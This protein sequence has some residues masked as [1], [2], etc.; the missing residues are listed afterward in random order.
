MSLSVGDIE[1]VFRL[2]D[3]FTPALTFIQERVEVFEH[4]VE[5]TA[6]RA[7]VAFD[8]MVRS[9]NGEHIAM[10]AA[11]IVQALDKIGGKAILTEAE[12]AR[13]NRTLDAA[14]LK[15][16]AMGIAIPAGL[17]PH[18]AAMDLAAQEAAE[19][20]T[21]QAEM[22]VWRRVAADKIALE[23]EVNRA[24][25]A[26]LKMREAETI[27]AA[28]AESRA[29]K[30]V[31]AEQIATQQAHIARLTQMGNAWRTV[32]R[33][34]VQVG[35]ALSMYVTL[36]LVAAGVAAVYFAAGF[37]QNMVKLVT[38]SAVT[39]ENML[40]MRSAVLALSPAVAVGPRELSEA[41]LQ[42]T[43]TGIR[44]MEAMQIL[45]V[46][47]KGAA[48]GM[49]STETVA[50][51]LTSVMVAY[52]GSGLTA[53]R[54][55]DILYKTVVEGK[56]EM[57]AFA[58]AMGRVVGM[59]AMVGVGL[60]DVG[61]YLATFT[62]TGGS[63]EEAATSLRQVLLRLEVK[64]TKN[65]VEVLKELGM[66]VDELRRSIKD[67]GLIVTMTDL[68]ARFGDA[69][70]S[71]GKLFPNI[72]ALSGAMNVFGVQADSAI[73]IV[74]HLT[75]D[76]NE[77]ELAFG[78]TSNTIAFK[79]AQ[80]KA[81]F[82]IAAIAIGDKLRPAILN[83]IPM[84]E[85][86]GDNLAKLADWFGKLSVVQ[87]DMI[88]GFIASVALLGPVIF[89][90]GQL[91]RAVSLAYD[92][93]ILLVKLKWSTWFAGLG[94]TVVSGGVL[95]IITLGLLDIAAAIGILMI[96]FKALTPEI[97][98]GVSSAFH[99]LW[100]ILKNEVSIELE[101]L[102]GLLQSLVE[103][104]RGV[105][106]AIGEFVRASV[107]LTRE[108][109]L[110][111]AILEWMASKTMVN[112][113]EKL[114]AEV[115]ATK[116]HLAELRGEV[117]TSE[118]AKRLGVKDNYGLIPQLEPEGVWGNIAQNTSSLTA[119]GAWK[120]PSYK[121]L[122]LNAGVAAA[123]LR[124]EARD[125]K[126]AATETEAFQ[127]AVDSLFNRLKGDTGP[128]IAVVS[129]AFARLS[130][131]QKDAEDSI[132]TLM[133]ILDNWK[134]R[135]VEMPPILQA[136]YDKHIEM[137]AAFLTAK[138]KLDGLITAYDTF[139]AQGLTSGE[140]AAKLKSGISGL[141]AEWAKLSREVPE[142]GKVLIA[143]L[144][145]LV[146]DKALDKLKAKIKEIE[147]GAHQIPFSKILDIGLKFDDSKIV[148][149]VSK[150]MD[151]L[152]TLANSSATF[153][154]RVS[155]QW[156]KYSEQLV[157]DF[158]GMGYSAE[159]AQKK[160]DEFLKTLSDAPS[161]EKA[162]AQVALAFRELGNIATM[163][164]STVLAKISS[165]GSIITGMF[166]QMA[167]VGASTASKIASAFSA[168][169]QVIAQLFGG[170]AGGKVVAGVFG[171][172]A[173]GMMMG[174]VIPGIGTAIGGF[175]GGVV[176]LIGGLKAAADAAA[177]AEKQMAELRKGLLDTYE[178]L[179]NIDTIGKAIGVDLAKL[180]YTDDVEAFN[181][182]LGEFK[183]KMDLIHAA[184]EQY[185]LTWKQMGTDFKN[186][187][188]EST[189]N[190][191][192][193]S[194]NALVSAGFKQSDILQGMSEDL[195]NYILDSVSMGLK[196]PPA[197]GIVI[198]RWVELGLVTQ[199]A[200]DAL[201]GYSKGAMPS[202]EDLTAA[203]G[204][205][206]MVLDDLGA[207][208]RK[209]Q[210]SASFTQFANDW[211]LFMAADANPDVLLKGMGKQIQA[212]FLQAQKLGMS[213]PETMRPVIQAMID[214]GKL[215]DK[216]GKIITDIGEVEFA[217]DLVTATTD[218]TAAIKNLTGAI[219]GTPAPG[220]GGGGGG[221]VVGRGTPGGT[222]GWN[223]PE[224]TATGFGNIDFGRLGS[225]ALHLGT[226]G[227]FG[228]GWND[229][230]DKTKVGV[231]S[232]AGLPMGGWAEGTNG[233]RDFGTGT[234][235]VLHGLEAVVTAQDYRMLQANQIQASVP[236][237]P[238]Q[239]TGQDMVTR[240]DSSSN[241]TVIVNNTIVAWDG[242]SVDEWLRKGGAKKVAEAIT[243][244]VPGIVRRYGLT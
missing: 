122:A 78:R 227:A 131:T 12:L 63:A 222:S 163:I 85:R 96:S 161:K 177:A 217:T 236:A 201:M 197:M 224:P 226:L 82:E 184:M 200:A 162:I 116:R 151:K 44:G 88:M 218:L 19:V 3:R 77:L 46:A 220:G 1:S 191:L 123:A 133:P 204:R 92:A 229:D 232:G 143:A 102:K 58:G 120:P 107:P 70:T 128:S 60:E 74:K 38:L 56:G 33:D 76:T 7:S 169:A 8:N 148:G 219:M 135:G 42:V 189:S 142:G 164:G 166:A 108:L 210:L 49:G 43:S 73:G 132:R 207:G 110:I 62:R 34:A 119:G 64:P 41:L 59:A 231:G 101:K 186:I 242:L 99:K 233:L 75:S 241:T 193:D 176:G 149:A 35:Q 188:W 51:S 67:K 228:S 175:V 138:N 15:S 187:E 9:L 18:A 214:A 10:E 5:T 54:A 139:I 213:L 238:G 36:P 13:V 90:F 240:G 81:A 2:V 183:T 109:E 55:G 180:W 37:E 126:N 190:R 106:P 20:A 53:A 45:E 137:S 192:L 165:V 230:S 27:A 225:A 80:V 152:E 172:V 4:N 156:R 136:W 199:A 26:A 29:W 198:R 104:F 134:K 83:I 23:V 69:N 202:L 98:E 95:S 16:R 114:D 244:M 111:N 145:G 48:V 71:L 206:G 66:T 100:E 30:M 113:N 31:A 68:V 112:Y 141:A 121:D 93:I 40:K 91:A 89:V 24:H 118:E 79:W 65:T 47:A 22:T 17:A 103:W 150:T 86:W 203:A 28:I 14:V 87:Q 185:G 144:Q 243:P 25:A 205:Y 178:S 11:I 237:L 157:Q 234:L 72:R 223:T 173:A 235:A 21:A 130:D 127:T 32:G 159:A 39:E 155:A 94:T 147:S 170:S 117:L 239:F 216:S 154:L 97:Q 146:D 196:I 168:A 6:N 125:A 171:G 195:T 160:V 129:A 84:L 115:R 153:S 211:K 57:T 158:I 52:A 209:M 212:A 167:V 208:V 50:K 215:V 182:A 61:A 105:L 194:Y 179:E 221:K 174:S 140:A 181:A 124:M